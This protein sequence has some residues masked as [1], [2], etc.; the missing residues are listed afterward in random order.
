M[1]KKNQSNCTWTKINVNL[2]EKKINVNLYEKKNQCKFIGKKNQCKWEKNQFH[3]GD[4]WVTS[5]CL[6]TF[7]QNNVPVIYYNF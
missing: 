2:Y 1:R 4:N 6:V 7:V 3:I 5:I